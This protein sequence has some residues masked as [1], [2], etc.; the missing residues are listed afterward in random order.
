M[1]S[2]KIFEIIEKYINS[3]AG[4]QSATE[5]CA[6]FMDEFYNSQD[7]LE[8]ELGVDIYEL[9]DDINLVCDSFEPNSEIRA[10]DNYCIDEVMLRKR[11]VELYNKISVNIQNK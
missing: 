2:D 3:D 5:F 11:V 7:D 4:I 8:S 6:D 9:F 1:S 10:N